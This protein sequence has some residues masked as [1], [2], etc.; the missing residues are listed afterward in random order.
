MVHFQS[1]RQRSVSLSTCQSE[2]V[3]AVSVMREGVFLQK[4]T[5]RITGVA[6]E[7]RL[8]ID[9][10]SS[11]QL[12]SRKGSGKARHFHVPLLGIQKMKQVLVK[13]IK[14]A[15]NRADLGTKALSRDRA[16]SLMSRTR[17]CERYRTRKRSHS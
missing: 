7:V 3:A 10:S 5:E 17:K 4:L 8:C 6:P 1:K 16:T 2:T 12:E 15:D 9:S 14:G 13:A 11:R